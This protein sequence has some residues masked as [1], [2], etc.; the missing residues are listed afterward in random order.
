[1]EIP[2]KVLNASI[3]LGFVALTLVIGYMGL[4][5]S[6][7]AKENP[8]SPIGDTI[9]EKRAESR[10]LDVLLGQV[11]SEIDRIDGKLL[12][13][14]NATMPEDGVEVLLDRLEAAKRS[15]AGAPA[16]P[17]E[18]LPSGESS[19]SLP[20]LTQS[21]SAQPSLTNRRL[22]REAVAL[23][24]RLFEPIREDSNMSTLESSSL[25]LTWATK[26]KLVDQ[27][28]KYGAEYGD[29]QDYWVR[30][31]RESCTYE[32]GYDLEPCVD[33]L[34]Y[35]TSKFA[36]EKGK[37]R[38]VEQL[39]ARKQRLEQFEKN[40][41]QAKET[42][43]T[44]RTALEETFEPFDGLIMLGA[45]ALAL[46]TVFLFWLAGWQKNSTA[47]A[48]PTITVLLL[49]SAIII[50]GLA[51]KL[52]KEVLG[53]LIGGISGYVLGRLKSSD[54]LPLAGGSRVPPPDEGAGAPESKPD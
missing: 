2:K 15:S 10:E 35:D 44:V 14:R 17:V 34:V 22:A 19:A 21:G 47:L 12:Q 29:V 7:A 39:E 1:M 4:K 33:L 26:F 18:D 25:Y 11:E 8:K 42:N 20:E 45:P 48:L 9:A 24:D 38:L 23:H 49:V 5:A 53:T 51:D 3:L 52:E 16:P 37:R 27:K 40:L 13:V 30:S 50:L 46:A 41:V 6:A 32:A 28:S 54:K 31:N 43:T 36:F